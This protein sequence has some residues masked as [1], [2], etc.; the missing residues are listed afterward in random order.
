MWDCD[1]NMNGHF[2]PE[3]IVTVRRAFVL[4]AV[5]LNI[6]SR[7]PLD[8]NSDSPRGIYHLPQHVCTRL[9]EAKGHLASGKF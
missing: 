8:I 5:F 6:T 2:I 9:G 4:I 1:R 3:N 7:H